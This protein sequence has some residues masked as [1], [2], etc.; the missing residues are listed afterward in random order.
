MSRRLLASAVAAALVL[1]TAAAVYSYSSY[2]KWP[3]TPVTIYINPANAD[4][5]PAAAS[6]AIQFAMNVWSTESGS[7]F[8]YQYGGSATDTATKLDNRNVVL[9]RN[10]SSGSTIAT[11]YSWWD[12]GNRLMDSDVI[13]WD[14]GFRFY[15]GAAGCGGIADSAYIED[16]ATHELGHALGLNHSTSTSATMYPSYGYCSQA[17]RTLAADDINGAKALY[18]PTTTNAAPVVTITSPANGA[19]FPAGATI[20]LAATATDAE[21][22]S[23]SSSVQWYDNGVLLGSGS[24]LSRVLS[25]VGV[26]TLTA[27]VTDSGGLQG[28]STVGITITLLAPPPPPPPTATL[29]AT[30]RLSSTGYHRV[31]LR[32][33]GLT[34]DSVDLFRNSVRIRAITNDGAYT[35]SIAAT[36][37]ATY[38]YRMCQK[39]STVCTNTVTVTY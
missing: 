18:P 15:T 34:G 17:F 24:L 7:S 25:L 26:H 13:F 30:G 22:G 16:I 2:A 5:P 35:D 9:F 27:R 29:T 21:D 33:S 14:N 10:A 11:T 1:T 4:V 6:T 8:R 3:S 23:L 28:T 31:D 36:G 20:S 12:S 39:A 19:T 38:S 37:S 32:W